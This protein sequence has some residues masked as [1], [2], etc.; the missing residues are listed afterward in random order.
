MEAGIPT[1]EHCLNL[2]GENNS[3]W[4]RID[5]LFETEIN[6]SDKK[7]ITSFKS[8]L[9]DYLANLIYE[10]PPRL[11]DKNAR[12][13]KIEALESVSNAVAK[14]LRNYK[15]IKTDMF[16]HFSDESRGFME[17]MQRQGN[18]SKND[19][20]VCYAYKKEREFLK[21]LKLL[22]KITQQPSVS[23]RKDPAI[24]N[25]HLQECMAIYLAESLSNIGV[26]PTTSREGFFEELFKICCKVVG[27]NEPKPGNRHIEAAVKYIKENPKRP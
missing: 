18:D 8:E 20:L 12:Q 25:A 23:P 14:L 3:F 10:N 13:M 7:A 4:R 11:A 2:I 26:K 19:D 6:L 1:F 16:L 21:N 27:F 5:H 22:Q 17:E 24:M 9:L 15:Y